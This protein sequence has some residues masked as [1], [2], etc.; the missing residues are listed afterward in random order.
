MSITA[1]VEAAYGRWGRRALDICVAAVALVVLLPIQLLIA[2]AVAISV[3]RPLWYR[4][5]RAGRD[6]VPFVLRKFRTMSE[7]RDSSGVLLPDDQRITAVGRVLRECS[8]DE[9][10][11][12]VNVLRGEMSLV[13]P[14]PLPL[15]YVQRYTAEQARRLQVKPGLTGFAQVHGRNRSGWDERFAQDVWYVDHRTMRLDIRVLLET[16]RVVLARD[17][18]AHQGQATMKEFGGSGQ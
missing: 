16:I 7:Q 6:G 8:L 13:G 14:R 5:V 11:Q 9:L 10:P 1:T 18:I 3:G 4:D 2:L 15:R 12:L 17:G